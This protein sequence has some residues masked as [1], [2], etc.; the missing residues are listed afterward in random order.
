MYK[1]LSLTI[2][3]NFPN[4]QSIVNLSSPAIDLTDTSGSSE[5]FHFLNTPDI[6]FIRYGYEDNGGHRYKYN[7]ITIKEN[8]EWKILYCCP[9]LIDEVFARN[10]LKLTSNKN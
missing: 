1:L 10:F 3:R 6:K 9:S 8:G 5:I 7:I 2:Q 4:T